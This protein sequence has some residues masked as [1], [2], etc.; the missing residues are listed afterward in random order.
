MAVVTGA[1]PW[2]DVGTWAALSRVRPKDPG[3]NVVVGKAFL[4]ESQDCIVW[5]D[6][7]PVILAGV[8][9]LVV[10]HAHG[11]ILVMPAE[12]AA[13]MKSLLDALP[14]ELRDVDP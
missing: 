9:D 10:V 13:A 6:G 4:H 2:D 11:R 5:S 3:G 8:Q 1:F 12:R 7:D 14:P